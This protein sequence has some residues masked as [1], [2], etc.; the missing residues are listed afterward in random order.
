MVYSYTQEEIDAA[1]GNISTPTETPQDGTF[2]YTQEEFDQAFSPS[3]GD[4][5]TGLLAELGVATG[6][7]M[8]AIAAGAAIGGPVGAGVAIAGT[9]GAGFLGSLVAQEIEGGETSIGRATAGGFLNFVKG[10]KLLEGVNASTKITPEL[11]RQV[12]ASEAKRGAAFG[13]GESTVASLIDTG[14]LP[15]AE[16]FLM[17]AAAGTIFGGGLGAILP[18]ATKSLSKF[19]GKTPDEIDLDITNGKITEEDVNDVEELNQLEL[20]SAEDTSL[21]DAYEPR[22]VEPTTEKP[23][24]EKESITTV[25]DYIRRNRR[26]QQKIKDDE[27]KAEFEESSKLKDVDFFSSE[28]APEVKV[29]VSEVADTVAQKE[30]NKILADATNTEGSLFQKALSYLVPSR[31]TG[32]GVHNEIF[33]A[34]KEL[35]AVRDSA[36]KFARNITEHLEQNPQDAA[37]VNRFLVTRT[38]EPEYSN[39]RLSATLKMFDKELTNLQKKLVNQLSTE[40]FNHLDVQEQNALLR[41]VSESILKPEQSYVTREYRAFI[42]KGFKFDAKQKELARKELIQKYLID[43][44]KESLEKAEAFANARLRT[45]INE[46]NRARGLGGNTRDNISRPNNGVIRFKEDLGVEERK[47]LGEVI[48]PAERI[49]GSLEGVGKLVYR[50]QVDINTVD[51]LKKLGLLS[52]NP[53]NDNTYVKLELPSGVVTKGYVPN[54]VQAALNRSFASGSLDDSADV[55]SSL[56]RDLFYSAIGASKAVKVIL[57]PPSYA[58]N[59]Y[60][61]MTT[62][63]GMGMNPFSKG[64]ARGLRYAASEYS[65]LEKKLTGDTELGVKELYLARDEMKK[66]G[67]GPANVLESDIRD[68]LNQGYFSKKLSN[69][70]DPLSKAYSATDTAARFGV[71]THNQQRLSKMFP[72][73]SREQIKRSAAQLTNDTFQNYEKLSPIVRAAQRIG[74]FPQFVAFT[75]EFSRNIYNQVRFAKQM[76]TGKFGQELGLDVSKAN[77]KAMQAEGVSRLVALS[78]VV[79]G[80]EAMRQGYNSMNNVD[81]ETEAMLKETAVADFDKN[82]SLLFTYDPETKEGSYA[83]MSYIVPH[84]IISEVMSSA[85]KDEPLS[86]LTGIFVDQFVGEGNF[87]GLSAYRAIDNRDAYGK[88]IS[89]DPDQMESFKN[90]LVYFVNETFKPGAVREGNKI[91]DSLVSDDPRYNFAEIMK[92]QLGNRIVKFN[93]NDQVRHKIRHDSKAMRNLKSD[94]TTARDYDKDLTPEALAKVYKDSNEV[95]ARVFEQLSSKD[96]SLRRLGYTEEERIEVLKEGGISSKDIIGL[97]DRQYVP[98]PINR[99]ESTSELFDNSIAGLPRAQQIS[100]MREVSQGNPLVF[101]KLVTEFKRRIKESRLNLDSRDKLIK[102]LSVSDRA[103]MIM[104]NPSLL[105]EFYRKGLISKSVILELKARGFRQ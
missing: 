36:S 37:F 29:R 72:Q 59:A 31:I 90:Q 27:V 58:V 5:A 17:S 88:T 87:V 35:S 95:R 1:F 19:A 22:K 79:A 51:Q 49:R 94:Y 71:W 38:I 76:A 4:I 85:F 83:N 80:T 24:L 46:S 12:A 64:T 65:W 52:D 92:R 57:N 73:A 21:I 70:F 78:G 75:A 96:E 74:V 99:A 104:D 23:T 89:D 28:V 43:N 102:N 39:T 26:L 44:P 9:F 61:A 98:I 77:Q 7:Q 14:Q 101:K 63:L 67:L 91:V 81:A 55:T 100:K 82:K 86:N 8:G 105:Q 34:N 66:Y 30:A 93:V 18:K 50:N 16:R 56:V 62:M 3:G 47:F 60:G 69:I 41:T 25:E 15:D 48:D 11:V 20:F 97:L 103:D 13:A 84:A 2:S 33:Q 68:T 54:V 45:L 42:D 53:V 10:S 6:G 40:R 32:Q